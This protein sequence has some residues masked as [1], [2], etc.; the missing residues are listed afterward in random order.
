MIVND[1]WASEARKL[2]ELL[3][4]LRGGVVANQIFED[5]QDVLSVLHDCIEHGPR[6]RGAHGFLIP[7]RENRSRDLDVPAQFCGGIAAEKQAVN[8]RRLALR[9]LKIQQRLFDRVG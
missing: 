5:S 6:S 9:E 4:F 2:T 8:K 7:F 3:Q 1:D